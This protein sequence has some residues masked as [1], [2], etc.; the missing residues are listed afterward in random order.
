MTSYRQIFNVFFVVASMIVLIA[1]I[2]F[3]FGNANALVA[4]L[5]TQFVSQSQ[6]K[7]SAKQA[8]SQVRNVAENVND[9]L[10]SKSISEAV[11]K[12]LEDTSQSETSKIT[13][14]QKPQKTGKMKRSGGLKSNVGWLTF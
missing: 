8:E 6:A 4:T 1:T 13:D 7:I 3:N 5:P 11:A 2:A 9:L 14:A 12:N 10:Q